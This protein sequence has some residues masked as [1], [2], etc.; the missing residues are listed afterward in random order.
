MLLAI[1]GFEGLSWAEWASI[2]VLISGVVGFFGWIL[3]RIISKVLEP[4]NHNIKS[5][6]GE[7][8]K[9]NETSVETHKLFAKRLDHHHDKLIHHD[10][11][12]KTLFHTVNKDDEGD[13]N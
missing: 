11:Q 2:F 4:L 1:H 5:L 13:D 7:I 9:L 12:I 8:A 6:S 3:Q 10:E